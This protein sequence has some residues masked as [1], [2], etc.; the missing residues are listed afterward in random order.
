MNNN[1]HDLQ[2]VLSETAS[3]ITQV[4]PNINDWPDVLFYFLKALEVKAK[5]L[6]P[7]LQREFENTLRYIIAGFNSRLGEG[8]WE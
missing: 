8:G 7:R 2:F 5:N 4:L 1:L 3:D 6:D